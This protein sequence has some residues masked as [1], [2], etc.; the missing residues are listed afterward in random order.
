MTPDT[1]LEFLYGLQ[2][3]GIKLGL[4]NIKSLLRSVDNP[5][6]GYGIIH[7]AGTN[8][9]G[10]V[11]AFLGQIYRQA[12]YRVGVYTSPHLHQFNER[13]CVDG[14]PISD[15]QLVL[16]VDELRQKNPQVPATFFEF[17][18]ALAL[19]HFARQQVDLVILEVGMGGRLDATNC[20]E[21][22]LSVI[23]PV[24]DDHGDYLGGSLCEIAAEKGGI[25]KPQAPLV[26][27]KQVDEVQQV[28]LG[29]ARQQQSPVFLPQ[30]QY[31]AEAMGNGWH[32]TTLN[33]CW[34]LLQP[35]L[36]GLHQGDNLATA[37]MAVEL[38]QAKGYAVTEQAVVEAVRNTRW[39][40]RLEWWDKAPVP[41]LLDGAHNAAGAQALA[42][43]L[44][45]QEIR[46]VHWVV[47]FK[48]DKD[49]AAVVG[50]LAPYLCCGYCVAPPVEAAYPPTQV[51]DSLR[52]QQVMAR[53]YG[54]VADAM[55]AAM[56]NCDEGEV[57]VVAGSL[58]LVAAAREWLQENT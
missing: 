31:Q 2:M 9:K 47:G 43:Y 37:L 18:T 49:M 7:V 14:Q 25:I 51:A 55:A 30:C 35:S 27:G 50:V 57:V 41:L 33:H 36:P 40:G 26:L 39:P 13:I 12:G 3:F 38:L 48:S 24:S 29:C 56:A 22:L 44:A 5:Q 8:G 21:P 28:L 11:C 10:S 15:A 52:Q 17:T 42:T 54:C 16:L 19:L 53:D 46:R 6:S 23:T 32:I 4:E 34:P 58:F 20:V 1:T 45:E